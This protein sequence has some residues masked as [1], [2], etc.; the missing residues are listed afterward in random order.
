[1]KRHL[2]IFLLILIMFLSW[3]GIVVYGDNFYVTVIIE[4]NK[5]WFNEQDPIVVEGRTLVPIRDACEQIN[6]KVLWYNSNQMVSVEKGDVK[7]TL[8][9]GSN[10]MYVNDGSIIYL[11]VAPAIYNGKTLLPIRAIFEELGYSVDWVDSDKTIIIEE[12]GTVKV[13][14]LKNTHVSNIRNWAFVSSVQQF[15]Y[16]G[17]GLAYAYINGSNLEIK[18]PNNQLSIGVKYPSLGD[19]ISDNEGNIYIVWG[20]KGKVN[21]DQTIFISKYS[22]EGIHIKTTGFIGES[23][24][25]DSGNTK[26]PFYAGNCNSAINGDYLMVNYARLTYK[27]HQSNNAI[28]VKISDMSPVVWSDIWDIPYTS[29]SFNQSVIWSELANEFVYADHGD[30]YGRGFVIKTKTHENILFHF[31]LEA[32]ANYDMS[33]INKTFAQLGNIAETSKGIVLV[34]S[35]AKSISESAKKE[36]QNLFVQIFDPSFQKVSASMFLGGETRKGETST[37][38]NDD[39][40]S[41]LKKVEDYGVHWLTNYSDTDAIAPQLI[42]VDDKL[43]ILWSTNNDTFY[44][45]LSASGDILTPATSIGGI[46]L[47][48]YERPVYHK[49]AIYWVSVINERL[50]MRSIDIKTF[51]VY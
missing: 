5:V 21:T 48:S 42:E 49:G 1:M 29:H 28:G 34:G 46:P 35:S 50:K 30:A 9:V 15:D 4:G 41:P 7:L 20:K 25:E 36:K 40:N 43:V 11:D 10:E 24:A 31:Y 51:N 19:V 39:N 33:I 13:P 26:E 37:N 18:L 32:N 3:T 27:G 45:I 38:I 6:A 12:L 14:G 22:P 17:E 44:M 2:S 8:K 16:M 47:N 23:R